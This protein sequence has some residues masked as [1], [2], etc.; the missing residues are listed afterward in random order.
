MIK[1]PKID[2]DSH[3]TTPP[4]PLDKQNRINSWTLLEKLPGSTYYNQLMLWKI[5]YI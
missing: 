5:Y 2:P 4:P 1:L 3:P